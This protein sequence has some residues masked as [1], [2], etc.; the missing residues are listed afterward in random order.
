MTRIERRF[1]SATAATPIFEARRDRR[2]GSRSI[3]GLVAPYEVETELLPGKLYERIERGAF[4][5]VLRDDVRLLLNHDQNH[6]IGRST[7][8]S[9]ELRDSHAG[10]RFTARLGDDAVSDYVLS[11][12]ED[13]RNTQMSFAF[14]LGD[15]ER[16]EMRTGSTAL[17]VLTGFDRL[18]DVS[19]VAFPAYEST[20][21]AV[22]DAARSGCVPDDSTVDCELELQRMR[23]LIDRP[24]KR[25]SAGLTAA[26]LALLRGPSRRDVPLTRIAVPREPGSIRPD[27]V[28]GPICVT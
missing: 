1:L 9:L 23:R 11:T 17:R 2:T 15:N 8:G 19:V 14:V 21:V 20:S 22:V 6:I 13:G 18:I 16:W 7:A 25:V 3:A 4:S 10:L 24:A 27:R 12:V 28:P 26:E 5:A